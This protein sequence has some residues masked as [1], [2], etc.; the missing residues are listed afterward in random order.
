[1][2]TINS[3]TNNAKAK[4]KKQKKDALYSQLKGQRELNEGLLDEDKNNDSFFNDRG[5]LGEQ[6]QGIV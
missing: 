4:A 3:L 1:M 5:P 2:S 6:L